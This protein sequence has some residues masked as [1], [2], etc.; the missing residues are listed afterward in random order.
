MRKHPSSPN[1]GSWRTGDLADALGATFYTTGVIGKGAAIFEIM[2]ERYQALRAYDDIA[3]H[4]SPSMNEQ[5]YAPS[6]AYTREEARVRS[7]FLP[8]RP[9]SIGG[10]R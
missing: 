7:Q 6:P 9:A 2:R 1:A 3:S 10:D 5:K 4:E 8:P